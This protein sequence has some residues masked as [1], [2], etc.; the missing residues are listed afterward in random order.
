MSRRDTAP[1][2]YLGADRGEQ[3]RQLIREKKRMFLQGVPSCL[4]DLLS[5][6]FDAVVENYKD[7]FESKLPA[8][9]PQAVRDWI[10]TSMTPDQAEA[11]KAWCAGEIIDSPS[12]RFRA[13]DVQEKE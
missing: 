10:G 6:A 1:M 13:L 9:I 5:V 2:G 12:P 4:K 7:G 3:K 8:D 11:W